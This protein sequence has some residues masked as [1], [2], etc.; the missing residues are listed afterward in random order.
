MKTTAV[1]RL[2]CCALLLLSALL[3]ACATPS[4]SSTPTICP[5]PRQIPALP[6]SLAAP[7]P[8]ENFLDDA[9]RD[10]QSWQDEL[11]ESATKPPASKPS[12]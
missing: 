3:Q 1:S 7:L 11:N 8:Q 4:P 6:P 12:R 5:P 2:A 10:A 9:M